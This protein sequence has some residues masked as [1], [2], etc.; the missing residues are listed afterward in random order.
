LLSAHCAVPDQLSATRLRSARS[1]G[2]DLF[3]QEAGIELNN[4]DDVEEVTNYMRDLDRR[5]PAGKLYSSRHRLSTCRNCWA[6]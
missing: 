6:S 5:Q 1:A 3:D 2:A 4:R